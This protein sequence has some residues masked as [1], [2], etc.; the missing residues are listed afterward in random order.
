MEGE[1]P[2]GQRASYRADTR[3]QVLQTLL[4]EW[5]KDKT[6]KVLVFTKSVKLLEILEYHVESQSGWHL[7]N[8]GRAL[9]F[10]LD[11]GYE[12]LDGSTEQSERKRHLQVRGQS[13]NLLS[14]PRYAHNRQIPQGPRHLDFF[15]LDACRR[16][17]VEPCW[18]EQSCH[19]R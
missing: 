1:H 2:V 18:G 8:T 16:D 3:C 4:K 6:N 17:R 10:H 9:T 13:T 7:Q 11:W 5:H 19:F 12:R 14:H 15:N